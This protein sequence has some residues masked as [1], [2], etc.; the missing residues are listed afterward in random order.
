MRSS[1]IDVSHTVVGD[2]F[3]MQLLGG[4]SVDFCKSLPLQGHMGIHNILM[5][6]VQM[7]QIEGVGS[8]VVR[9]GYLACCGCEGLVHVDRVLGCIEVE[10]VAALERVL[11]FS[12]S[13]CVC[14]SRIQ[15]D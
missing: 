3:T 8:F 13:P 4:I 1:P 7:V 9:L 11:A 15:H 12:V 14:S 5:T 10:L 2:F 6:Y